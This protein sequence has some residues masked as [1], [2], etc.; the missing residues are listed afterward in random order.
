MSKKW[1]SWLLLAVPYLLTA[2]IP[3]ISVLFL[4]NTILTSYQ[5]KHRGRQ[6]KQPSG[7]C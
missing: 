3:V 4:S 5:E 7:C 6:A 1:R 2:L